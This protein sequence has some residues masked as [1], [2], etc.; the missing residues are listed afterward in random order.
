MLVS[1][2]EASP[3]V[4]PADRL[5]IRPLEMEPLDTPFFYVG[6]RL[7]MNQ[8]SLLFPYTHNV[9][10]H[11]GETVE[12]ARPRRSSARSQRASY[13]EIHPRGPRNT[14]WHSTILNGLQSNCIL[15]RLC[16][17]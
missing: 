7:N 1:S 15:Y 4:R 17:L 9:H 11:H 6:F 14:L 3:V 16:R 5:S 13:H 2:W 8:V 10:S 12:D